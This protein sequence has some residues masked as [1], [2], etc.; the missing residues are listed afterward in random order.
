MKNFFAIGIVISILFIGCEKKE[1]LSFVNHNIINDTCENCAK[2]VINTPQAQPESPIAT[3]INQEV[4]KFIISIL[5]YSEER[6]TDSLET[7][8]GI[9]K[10]DYKKLK[11]RFPED[12]IP[13]EAT[14]NGE[15]AFE[16][17]KFTS[18]KIDS[19]VFT[20]GAH[21]YGSVSYLNFDNATGNIIP[22]KGLFKDEEA[23]IDYAEETFRN[24]EKIKSDANI[25]STGFMFEDDNFH[26]PNSIGFNEKGIILIY[27]PYEISA[28][29]DG[30][31]KIE[32]P[33]EKANEFIKPEWHEATH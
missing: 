17:E 4:D 3:S 24:Q 8:I 14:I 5:N 6:T 18:I 10:N 2:V 21:G 25:N 12:I 19:Y 32:I 28:Y 27:N 33:F 16:N 7:A 23:F 29:A 31:T 26:L 22:S 20:G 9:F 13:W 30:L 15:I 11:E 1:T